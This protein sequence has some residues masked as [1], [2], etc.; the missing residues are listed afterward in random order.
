MESEGEFALNRK[1]ITL[2]SGTGA[3]E[4]QIAV[5]IS[6]V[7]FSVNSFFS[8]KQG[9]LW[10]SEVRSQEAL[11]GIIDELLKATGGKSQIKIRRA[12]SGNLED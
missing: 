8:V 2:C 1:T 10:A 7:Q 5:S 6:K 4:R 3:K 12:K 11:K 9:P